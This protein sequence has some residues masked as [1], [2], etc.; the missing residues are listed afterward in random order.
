MQNTAASSAVHNTALSTSYSQHDSRVISYPGGQM[1]GG[2]GVD[3]TPLPA[4][5][6]NPNS[7]GGYLDT[8]PPDIGDWGLFP[9][10]IDEN[11][12]SNTLE[13]EEIDC[14][15]TLFQCAKISI[16]STTDVEFKAA[17][18][19]VSHLGYNSLAIKI[20]GAYI[21]KHPDVSFAAYLPL[22]L[23]SLRTIISQA[24]RETTAYD[25]RCAI[26]AFE[27]S[28]SAIAKENA[29]AAETLL[30]CGFLHNDNIFDDLIWRGLL[31]KS[32][33]GMKIELLLS[34]SLIVR[35]PAGDAFSIPPSVHSWLRD[36]LD[37][38]AREIKLEDAAQLVANLVMTDYR[39]GGGEDF[40][41]R[42]LPHL[43]ACW[44]YIKFY[45]QSATGDDNWCIIRSM[46]SMEFGFSYQGRIKE[47]EEVGTQVLAIQTRVLG[48]V[49][50]DTL[51]SMSC[52][53]W[54]YSEQGRWK[55]ADELGRRAAKVARRTLGV[56]HPDTLDIITILAA[57]TKEQGRWK[58]AE[59]L[60]AEV[61]STGWKMF[62]EAHLNNL[63]PM[64]NLASTFL[65][66]GRWNEAED[67]GVQTVS[68]L[69]EQ[70]G[71]AHKHTLRASSNL[72][73]TI[74]RQGRWKE[75]VELEGAVLTIKKKVFGDVHPD[76]LE[77]IGNLAWTFSRQGLWTEAEN[78]QVQVLATRMKVL[79]QAHPDTLDLMSNIAWTISRQGRLKEAEE[80]QAGV[81][82]T[83]KEVLGETHPDT[84]ASMMDLT[85]ILSKQQRWKEAGGLG[86]KVVKLAKTELGER[87]PD[88]LRS[89]SILA[90]A[91][92]GQEKWEDAERL[93]VQ[94]V[95]RMKRELG[96]THP[97]TLEAI[98]NLA[99]TFSGQGRWKEA[100]DL[101]V[102]AVALMKKELGEMHPDTVE[103]MKKLKMCQITRFKVRKD[104]LQLL[105]VGNEHVSKFTS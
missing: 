100:E 7:A 19:L 47:A 17:E 64:C 96:E 36:R 48:E 50:P 43:E 99:W 87:H 40:G 84:L 69:K 24:P 21:A 34:Y 75:A 23:N 28:F 18:R 70:R 61:L 8:L 1:A 52:L 94:V 68:M 3:T 42:V 27:I 54:T 105:A 44:W 93:G 78:L 85:W 5:I 10:S 51:V 88:T 6:S 33:T 39:Q 12:A 38:K 56:A 13:F 73:R 90:W 15:Q 9:G 4:L 53:A 81:L 86:V 29:Q 41:R 59:T 92:S 80:L 30:M 46:A 102:Q 57:I 82:A 97:S 60:E 35:L 45:L 67:L 32:S 20:A 16:E 101:G 14:L 49:H 104:L 22:Y 31:Q 83:M 63:G 62:G 89:V 11:T 77:S 103:S 58:E 95:E 91:F 71:E 72:A 76:T 25:S 65:K 37:P 2:S 26:A 66:Q 98:A 74:S 55:Q 79:G